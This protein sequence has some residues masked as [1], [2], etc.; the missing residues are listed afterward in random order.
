MKPRILFYSH[1]SSGNEPEKAISSVI[2][3][4]RMVGDAIL[5]ALKTEKTE[6]AAIRHVGEYIRTRFGVRLEEYELASNV[7]GYIHYFKRKGLA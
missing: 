3:N 7:K 4:T 1:G 5:H 2:K 6:E